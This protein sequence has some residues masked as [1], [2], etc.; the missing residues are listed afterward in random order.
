MV[1]GASITGSLVTQASAPTA[2]DQTNSISYEAFV[3]SSNYSYRHSLGKLAIIRPKQTFVVLT[4]VRQ[5][6]ECSFVSAIE[7]FYFTGGVGNMV[8]PTPSVI[9]NRAGCRTCPPVP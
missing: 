9:W 7:Y 5:F 1:H 2:S 6:T 8:L 3:C 4:K